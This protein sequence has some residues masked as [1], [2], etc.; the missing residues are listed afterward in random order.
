M[1]P[2][3]LS[4]VSAYFMLGDNDAAIEWCLRSL[5][6]NPDL[7][8]DDTPSGDGIRPQR[9]GCQ[10][11][12]RC[13]RGAPIGSQQ[14][15]IR[16]AERPFDVGRRIHGMVREQ[17]CSCVAQGRVA[18][19]G[20]TPSLRSPSYIDWHRAARGP[21][22]SELTV[23]VVAPAIDCATQSLRLCLADR[24]WLRRRCDYHPRLPLRN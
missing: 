5:E 9:G 18:G 2:P 23:G 11:A 17:A 1:K 13:C 6:K 21:T 22:V 8:V 10:G 19:V 16:G 15:V 7:S 3:W 4:W 12:C 14:H 20:R 24:Y